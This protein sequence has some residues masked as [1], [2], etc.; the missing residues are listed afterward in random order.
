MLA[1]QTLLSMG[2]VAA[3]LVLPFL[4]VAGLAALAT[5]AMAIELGEILVGKATKSLDQATARKI[6]RRMCLG[7]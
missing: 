2:C 4:A 5:H 1:K 6:A 3:W 7:C